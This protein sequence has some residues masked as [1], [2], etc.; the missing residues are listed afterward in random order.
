MQSENTE[1]SLQHFIQQILIM[2]RGYAAVER[3]LSFNKE[4]LVENLSEESLIS[5]RLVHD[6]VL[7]HGGVTQV[8]ITKAMIQA[9]TGS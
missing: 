4:Y 6:V 7:A 3:S 5:Q 8:P 2:F 1:I 9:D